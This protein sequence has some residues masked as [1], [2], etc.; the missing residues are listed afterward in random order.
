MDGPTCYHAVIVFKSSHDFILKRKLLF[1]IAYKD[2]S[3]LT[4]PTTISYSEKINGAQNNRHFI[5]TTLPRNAGRQVILNFG[6]TGH[7]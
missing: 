2:G 1:K 5:F 6:H 3:I 7:E 4:V